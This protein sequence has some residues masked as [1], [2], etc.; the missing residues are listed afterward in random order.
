MKRR[1]TPEADIQR[2]VVK[3]LRQVLPRGSIL[4]HSANEV[5]GGGKAAKIKQGKG[6]GEHLEFAEAPPGSKPLA[7]AAGKA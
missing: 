1:G 4:H 5:T 3:D 6:Q 7:A 2:A